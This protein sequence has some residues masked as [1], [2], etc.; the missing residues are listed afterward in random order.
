VTGEQ[1]LQRGEGRGENGEEMKDAM[2]L[3][4]TTTLR[5]GFEEFIVQHSRRVC[6]DK[7][8]TAA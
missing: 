6:A 8:I 4:N 5:T 7:Q 2:K 1:P 3:P